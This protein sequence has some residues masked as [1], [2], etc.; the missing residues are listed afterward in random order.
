MRARISS[1]AV[2]HPVSLPAEALVRPWRTATL[3][4]SAVA[5]L[6]LLVLVV[7][8]IVLLGDSVSSRAR[9]NVVK[10]AFAQPKPKPVSQ[11][12]TVAPKLARTQTSLLVLNGSGRQGA[13][14]ATAARAR[15]HGYAISGVG[16]ATQSDY[17]KSVVMYRAGRR[18]EAQ[19][20]AR[21]LGIKV[22]GPLD[23]LK[24]SDLMGAHVA[25]VLGA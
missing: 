10:Q 23:G 7:V 24:T 20:L 19:R 9:E 1:S 11:P 17:G 16:N 14:A 18:G 21:D 4:A 6:E 22:V 25:V 13:A 5:A 3:V 8:G 2:D 12:K 15:S